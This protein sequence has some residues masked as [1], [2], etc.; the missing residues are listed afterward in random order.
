M[1]LLRRHSDGSFQWNTI[2]ECATYIAD[3]SPD[4]F[5]GSTEART[6]K[7]LITALIGVLKKR[8]EMTL[9]RVRQVL[10]AEYPVHR[11]TY[12]FTRR[13][14]LVIKLLSFLG[15]VKVWLGSGRQ[16]MVR[17]QS[18]TNLRTII[19]EFLQNAHYTAKVDKKE[20]KG[21]LE[22]NNLKSEAEKFVDRRR[23]L[24]E[25]GSM[26][27]TRTASFDLLAIDKFMQKNQNIVVPTTPLVPGRRTRQKEI[28]HN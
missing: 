12:F 6:F 26:F 15:L 24:R 3:K 21:R 16:V 4:G 8:T 9:S 7:G 5:K 11:C 23:I 22:L 20:L 13:I 1:K 17:Y 19:V 18:H 14:G 27:K 10:I 28:K 25:S 2:E